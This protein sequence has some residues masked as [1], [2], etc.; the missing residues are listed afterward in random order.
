MCDWGTSRCIWVV[1][2]LGVTDQRHAAREKLWN[3]SS[4]QDRETA[5]ESVEAFVSVVP[6]LAVT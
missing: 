6:P 5:G 3:G 1:P 2:R 4:R